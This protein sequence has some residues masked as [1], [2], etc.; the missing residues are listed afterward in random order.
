MREDIVTPVGLELGLAKAFLRD[1]DNKTAL[2]HA[3]LAAKL[4][5][6]SIEM[7]NHFGPEIVDEI[8]KTGNIKFATQRA[9]QITEPFNRAVAFLKIAR[10]IVEIDPNRQA[11]YCFTKAITALAELETFGMCPAG[12]EL[13]ATI[14]DQLKQ[15]GNLPLAG[16]VAAGI[17]EEL[18]RA[19]AFHGIAT[20]ASKAG[21]PELANGFFEKALGSLNGKYD[22]VGSETHLRVCIAEALFENGNK[23]RAE[24]VAAGIS[25]ELSRAKAFHGIATLASKAGDPDLANGF[26]EKALGSLNGKYDGVGSETHLRV[27]IAEALF[28]NGNKTRA[29]EVAAGISE[30][31]SRAKAFLGIAKLALKAGDPD[32]ANGFFEKALGSL[33]GKYDGAGSE[34]KLRVEIREASRQELAHPHH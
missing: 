18:S 3:A 33:N 30:E 10:K 15:N 6:S 12:V 19:Q 29:E 8:C 32:L 28:E 11:S 1:G 16:E 9:E 7:R 26:F 34:T 17:S 21:D 23:T 31:L 13:R 4:S 27:C 20:L 24:E 2:K 14:L 25:E 5:D 22:G